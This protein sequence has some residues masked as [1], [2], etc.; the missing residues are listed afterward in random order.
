MTLKQII[1]SQ[2]LSALLSPNANNPHVFGLD[3]REI[4]FSDDPILVFEGQEDVVFW[5]KV[6][7]DH[8]LLADLPT[9]GWG[10]GGAANMK[11]VVNVLKALGYQRVCG[12]LDNNRPLDLA[13]LKSAFPAFLF[14]ELPAADI[15]TKPAAPVR[16]EV[17]GLLNSSGVIQPELKAELDKRLNALKAFVALD[18]KPPAEPPP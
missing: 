10:A 3:A 4:F 7:I 9:Y 11:N 12:V 13:N 6:I 5:P 16:L 8:P 15:R 17:T 1:M 2:T 14:V 18:T